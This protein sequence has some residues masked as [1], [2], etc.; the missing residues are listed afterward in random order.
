LEVRKFAHHHPSRHP[1]KFAGMSDCL[2][3]GRSLQPAGKFARGFGLGI[4][5]MGY[6]LPVEVERRVDREKLER[7]WARSHEPSCV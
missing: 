7:V 6:L 2:K 3:K 4:F 1:G 5:I